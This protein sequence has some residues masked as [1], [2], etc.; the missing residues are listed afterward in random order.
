M[1][2]SPGLEDLLSDLLTLD[3]DVA[4]PERLT[5]EMYGL[6]PIV[7]HKTYTESYARLLDNPEARF[8]DADSQRHSETNE[9]DF[10]PQDTYRLVYSVFEPSTPKRAG[11]PEPP[12]LILLPGVPVNR[13]EWFPVARIL[14][15]FMRVVVLDYLGMGESS[16]PLEFEKN[17]RWATQA[18]VVHLFVHH[19]LNT[20]NAWFETGYTIGGSDWGGGV[21]QKYGELYWDH[22]LPHMTAL[23][24]INPIALN[25]YWTPQIGSLVAFTR[26]VLE[27]DNPAQLAEVVP[28]LQ[29]A[30]EGMIGSMTTLLESMFHRTAEIHNKN[31]LG[32][33]QS[34]YFNRK[35]YNNVTKNAGNTEVYWGALRCL[36]EQAAEALGNG[37]LL[38]F[39]STRNP[40]GLHF[41]RWNFPVLVTWGANDKMMPDNQGWRFSEII[42]R[43]IAADRE[44]RGVPNKLRVEYKRISEAGHFSNYDQP[45]ATVDAILTFLSPINQ[46]ATAARRHAYIG[47]DMITRQDEPAL[48][49]RLDEIDTK[50]V[51]SLST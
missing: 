29:V 17:W 22:M 4:A 30:A 13:F 23:W 15:R 24:I 44:V 28:Q 11:S 39:H 8:V 40:G 47:L 37:E 33:L 41:T 26:L 38:P 6:L 16:Q 27:L 32:W 50:L 43:L 19:L 10:T 2:S 14:G 5:P 51:Q 48:L 12:L 42:G 46:R 9:V 31:S 3:D 1:T 7:H 20:Q 45:M 35:A 34:A 36:A 21:A 18:K 49:K 25:G